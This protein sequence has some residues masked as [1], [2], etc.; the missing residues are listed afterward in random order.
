[1]KNILLNPG[2]VTLSER[3]RAAL[4]RPD[5]CHREPEFAAL[6]ND[7][8]SRLLAVYD[9]DPKIWTA[10]LLTCSGTGAVEA[11]VGSLAATNESLVVIENGV[12]GERI[13]SIA[14]A[15]RIPHRGVHLDWGA[16]IDADAAAAFVAEAG[17]TQ[18]AV[19]HH[20]TT[21]GRLNALEEL[22]AATAR[23]STGGP[24]LLIDAVSSFGA[25]AIDFEGWRI[26]AC[27]ATANKCLHGVPG[28]S[29]VIVRRALLAASRPRGV[30]FNLAT[31]AAAQD[32]NTTPFT[33]S[34]QACYALE[35][36][37]AEFEDEGGWLARRERYRGFSALVRDGLAA[38][39]VEPLLDPGESSCVLSSFRLPHGVTYGTLHDALKA[40]GITIYAGP[41]DLAKTMFRIAV[42]G[43]ITADDLHRMLD[44]CRA[45]LRR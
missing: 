43:A 10:I 7:I 35:E 34:V 13:S 39:G 29:F 24:R 3:V 14:T 37:L 6:Q 45:V 40:D 42:M 44:R 38:L 15:Y 36:A 32:A 17:A 21:T 2:P 1:M 5:L 11:M 26:D 22:A 31:Y 41:G 16:R 23:G 27:A 33:Q 18:L 28:I 4:S 19:I 20:E 12:Y 8:R 25:E 9:L 30:Y